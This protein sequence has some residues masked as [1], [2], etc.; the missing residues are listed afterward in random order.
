[1]LKLLR[2]ARWRE[3]YRQYLV[4][5]EKQTFQA[6]GETPASLRTY[7]E[8]V[9]GDLLRAIDARP[10]SASTKARMRAA[11]RG[12]RMMLPSE[13]FPTNP[14]EVLDTCE[15]TALG[16]NAFAMTDEHVLIVCPIPLLLGHQL[17]QG[18]SFPEPFAGAYFILAHELGHF[19]DN[20]DFPAEL[21]PF[22]R[23]LADVQGLNAQ[24]DGRIRASDLRE[25]SADA[26]AAAA[27]GVRLGGLR[28]PDALAFVRNSYHVFC[29]GWDTW[30][31][32]PHMPDQSRLA[33]LVGH[34]PALRGRLG[35]PAP[36]GVEPACDIAGAVTAP[37]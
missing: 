5:L 1:M 8:S 10:F 33:Y 9:R 14:D 37:F 19:I 4:E 36:T 13:Y 31:D 21:E 34:S 11:I 24:P 25:H 32:D 20:G 3:T 6:L 29:T 2:P 28:A 22:E 18:R 30:D 15:K 26:W 23:C 16:R 12:A 35:C 27:A 17:G 7:F